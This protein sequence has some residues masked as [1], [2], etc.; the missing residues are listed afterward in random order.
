[1]HFFVWT[2]VFFWANVY[3][4]TGTAGILQLSYTFSACLTITEAEFSIVYVSRENEIHP[5]LMYKTKLHNISN[6][7][8]LLVMVWSICKLQWKE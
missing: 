4:L 5:R 6:I 8:F 7:I 2:L 3:Q 1:M